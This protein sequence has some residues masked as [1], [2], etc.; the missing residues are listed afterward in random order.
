MIHVSPHKVVFFGREPKMMSAWSFRGSQTLSNLNYILSVEVHL[1]SI[2]DMEAE[3]DNSRCAII[4]GKSKD[5]LENFISTD[6]AVHLKVTHLIFSANVVL[7]K[8]AFGSRKIMTLVDPFAD[9][10]DELCIVA[11]FDIDLSLKI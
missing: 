4:D 7:Q 10:F 5:M 6:V 11:K 2:L 8:H 3:L 9:I 1:L